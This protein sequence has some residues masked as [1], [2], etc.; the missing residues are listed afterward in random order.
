[1]RRVVFS[2]FSNERCR[3]FAIRTDIVAEN[4]QKTVCKSACYPQGEAHVKN[5][6]QWYERL[7]QLF[8]GDLQVNHAELL[9]DGSVAL[10][11]L[12]DGGTLEERLYRLWHGGSE[13][14]ALA[15]MD[16]YLDM[17]KVRADVPFEETNEFRQ[18]FGEVELPDGLRCLPVTDLDMVTENIL[19][20][21]GDVWN[22][23]DYEWSFAFPIPVNFVLYRI[24]H[25]FLS[26]TVSESHALQAQY[27]AR[28]G[29]TTQEI[30]AY[31]QMETAFQRYVTGSHV[32]IREMYRE[33]TPGCT[34]LSQ[35]RAGESRRA[36]HSFESSL[37]AA[38]AKEP[39]ERWTSYAQMQVE[40][41]GDFTVTFELNEKLE[42]EK[43]R[44]NLRWDPLEGEM[45]RVR[46]E[47][48]CAKSLLKIE[49]INGFAEDGGDTFWTYDPAY[50]LT[51]DAQNA[52]TV[53]IRGNIQILNFSETLTEMNQVRVQRDAYWAELENVRAQLQGLRATKSFKVIE[54]LRRVRNS[55]QAG[56]RQ[57]IAQRA[58]S[59]QERTYAYDHKK[60][61]ADAAA[62]Q[63]QKYNEFPYAPKISILV[64]VYQTP[65]EFLH[66]MIKSVQAQT[67]RN[68]EL[69]LADGGSDKKILSVLDAY[70]KSDARIKV[71]RLK[72]NG[73]ISA[74]T[75]GAAALASGDYIAL[76]DHD[77]M[78]APEALY[79]VVSAMQECPAEL[80]YTDEDIV[81][82]DGTEHFQPNLKPDFS[83]DLLRSHNYITHFLVV[84]KTLFEQVG[85][86]HTAF[87][88]AQDYDLILRC[89]EQTEQIAHV[90]K[91]LYHWRAHRDSTAE[92]P[93]SKRY[94]YEAGKRALEAHLKRIGRQARVEMLKEWG[95]YRVIYDTVENPLVSVIIP[96]K[97]HTA[98][99]D[100]CIR[101]VMERSAYRN[102]EIFVIENNSENAETFAYY[103]KIQREFAQVRVETWEQP[104]NYSAINN[105]GARLA[106]GDYLLFLN[107]DT[108]LL[109]ADGIADMLGYCMQE[110]T[111][112]V[113]AK[114][115]YADD[116]VQHAGIVLG[117]GSFAG[118]VFTG[119][120]KDDA[121]YMMRAQIAG[122]Y[123][124]VTAACMMVRRDVYERVGGFPEEFP[125]A[126]NDVEF[127]MRVRDAGYLIV[128]DAFAL[129]HHYE[130]KTRGYEDTPQK[131]ERFKGEIARFRERWG[132]VVDAGDPYYNPNFALDREPFMLG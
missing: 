9:A 57:M 10:A 82:F 22:L 127:C 29:L 125:V 114:L 71:T 38:D 43:A 37:F 99:L 76:L 56:G 21:P 132:D 101:S 112:C 33:I 16:R 50:R 113:G 96:N 121:G 40:E 87:D 118:H 128:F 131:Q 46:V 42:E 59:K 94:A 97:D 7:Q 8:D 69:C 93:E 53:T 83:P 108:E 66:A 73:G 55:V 81:S 32:P 91:I 120:P 70:A 5:I 98:D 30:R 119:K 49:P 89:S 63:T 1:M 78:L 17:L 47:A 51:G 23:I 75:N 64:P 11:F 58:A 107:N 60:L 62:L 68:W 54:G 90:A 35:M 124:A 28:E 3:D 86:L 13:A 45:C 79:E 77:D 88:G 26:R 20:T 2:K 6:V 74:N 109:A 36:A 48:V 52:G 44:G 14:E 27:F 95:M 110:A 100:R 122:N 92:N 115:L 111:G 67:Y 105:L 106:K 117:F 34:F 4:G 41:N 19:I 102:L 130:S 104:F 85:G 15:L 129:W 116:T 126:L 31:E 61:L 84:K 72:E 12:N 123:S 39:S 24:W 80:L 25:Y 18:M 103:E 65:Q